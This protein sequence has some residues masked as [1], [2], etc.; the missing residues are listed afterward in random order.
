[1][2]WSSAVR[3]HGRMFT[4]EWDRRGSDPETFNL[5]VDKP[6]IWGG[7]IG[8]YDLKEADNGGLSSNTGLIDRS[9]L[10]LCWR[11]MERNV[12][13]SCDLG[14]CGSCLRD[15]SKAGG[16]ERGE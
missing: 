12:P 6:G 8:F 14:L 3:F 13:V 10:G 16:H 11:C 5:A 4:G 9:W 1:M 2:S 15:L 7:V